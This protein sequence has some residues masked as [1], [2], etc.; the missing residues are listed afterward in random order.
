MKLAL[1]PPNHPRWN[2]DHI[3]LDEAA[4]L[5]FWKAVDRLCAATGL[6][7][8]LEFRGLGF[9]NEPT[10]T[11][12]D[13]GTRVIYPVFDD[14]PFRVSLVSLEYQHNV[15]F[16]IL[17]WPVPARANNRRAIPR[18]QAALRPRAVTS[19]QCSAQFQVVAE[20]RLSL[21]QTGCFEI[22]EA[23]DDRGNSLVSEGQSS[24]MMLRNA[25]YM[26]GMSTAVLHLRAP[27]S[28]PEDPGRT[29]KVLRGSIP[30]RVTSRQTDPL[31]VPL[32]D[33]A[34]KS[35]DKGDLHLSIHEVRTDAN[36]RQR[37]I[38]LSVHDE[39]GDLL[40]ASD[41]MIP[42]PAGQPSTHISR[43][44]RSST[45]EARACPCFRPTSISRPPGSP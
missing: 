12:T 28:R 10:L 22:L 44:S 13:R 32:A 41:E 43:T 42:Q 3:T 2:T 36:H 27:L 17:P 6:Q 35:F 21:S 40:P 18:E 30:L 8:D 33:A 37:Q 38:E 34:G 15:G 7:Y 11:L 20:P 29:I 5:P 26:G 45:P 9:R 24:P 4:P 39:R 16:A 1:F 31:V 14:G 25:G 19:V 23:R